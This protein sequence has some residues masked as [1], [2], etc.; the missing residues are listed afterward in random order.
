V[1]RGGLGSILRGA[2]VGGWCERWASHAALARI[3]APGA[4]DA[5]IVDCGER[6][7]K[8]P[9]YTTMASTIRRWLWAL[10]VKSTE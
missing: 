10:I 1:G 2:K 6:A 8:D 3:C 4:R 5:E 9:W 7:V